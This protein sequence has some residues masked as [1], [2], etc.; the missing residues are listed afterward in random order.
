MANVPSLFEPF[1]QMA[2]ALTVKAELPSRTRELV[3]L[4]L[5][6][7][8]KCIPE[9]EAHSSIARAAGVTPEEIDAMKRGDLAETV[10]DLERKL[11]ALA[12]SLRRGDGP[13]PE[14]GAIYETVG[15]T[16]YLEFITAVAW[17]GGCIP[18]IVDGLGVA[19]SGA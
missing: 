17:W 3:V 12:K 14:A 10:S 9:F 16:R 5:A 2:R 13:T 8:T 1:L 7:D 6:V 15:V 4:A 19:A 18:V 11:I